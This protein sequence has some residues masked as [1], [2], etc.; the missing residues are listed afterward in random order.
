[1][2]LKGTLKDFG[3]ADIL[4][5]IGQQQKSGA[6]V[7]KQ[8]GETVTVSFKDGNIVRAETKSR[9]DKDLIGSMLVAGGV[10]NSAQLD[11]AL[12]VQKRTLQRL[13]DVLVSQRAMTEEKFKEMVQLQSNETLYRLFAWKAGNYEFEVSDIELDAHAQSLRAESVL[14]E[15][16]RR[17][18]E[19]P[20]VRKRITSL[21]MS[22]ERLKE[23]PPPPLQKDSFDDALDDAFGEEKKSVNK[24][25]FQSVGENERKVYALIQPGRNVERIIELSCLG[26]FEGA[27]SLCNLLNLE[28]IES[29]AP[30]GRPRAEFRADGPRGSR[31]S[32]AISVGLRVLVGA[33][34][35]LLFAFILSR[36]D[37]G[38]VQKS[39]SNAASYADPAVQRVASKQQ[40]TRIDAALALFKLEKGKAPALL[41]DLVQVGLLEESDL[42][43]PWKD[44][45]FY[46]VDS[47][48]TW[49]LL[50]PLR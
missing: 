49:V 35:V 9:N 20:M 50:P 4:Q 48:G 12:E 26:E 27:K 31:I 6:L 41:E 18:D 29:K 33:V 13:G 34:I 11:N 37:L 25:E 21:E 30:L 43:Y 24:G 14:M 44:A 38:S 28:Y 19:W 7:L 17:V 22:F 45:Y 42:S 23:L 8:K 36:V 16:F 32:Q 5:L 47:D 46:R 15:G 39:R 10:I 3:I 1:M 2:A 40:M